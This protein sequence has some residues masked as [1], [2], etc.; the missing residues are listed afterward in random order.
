MSTRG[1]MISRA[2]VWAKSKTF[3][4][5]SISEGLSAP[6][7]WECA[8]IARISSSEWAAVCCLGR[9]DFQGRA[10]MI[11]AGALEDLDQR[12][13]DTQEDAHRARRRKS[14][15]LLRMRDDPPFRQKLA[16]DDME[17]GDEGKT[18]GE[19]DRR[20][21][22]RRSAS[23]PARRKQGTESVRH[24]GLADVT[25]RQGG[26]GDAKLRG[27]KVGADAL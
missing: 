3:S 11:V 1:T 24:C 9:L 7:R 14:A 17:T 22:G 27:R 2:W 8:T 4:A 26:D 13:A 25:E 21:R 16:E 18:D 20:A 10:A 15:V 12:I 6:S 5:I 23:M 19:C